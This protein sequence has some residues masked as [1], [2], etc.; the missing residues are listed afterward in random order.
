MTPLD[1]YFFII[2][3]SILYNKNWEIKYM[4]SSIIQ[5]NYCNQNLSHILDIPEI[6]NEQLIF[7]ISSRPKN[8]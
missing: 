1:K 8:A 4:I 7:L 2:C 3:Q 5:N 6:N